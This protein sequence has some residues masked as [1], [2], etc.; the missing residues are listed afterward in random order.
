MRDHVQHAHRRL[1]ADRQPDHHDHGAP[2]GAE[3][4]PEGRQVEPRL[5]REPE[6][7]ALL[8][9]QPE[10]PHE[11]EDEHRGVEHVH[12]GVVP[13]EGPLGRL[14][15]QV[16]DQVALSECDQVESAAKHR[17]RSPVPDHSL[18]RHQHSF[19]LARCAGG[20]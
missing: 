3:R 13:G 11:Q 12:K 20:S 17:G 10:C 8:Q 5:A 15:E 6:I 19:L 7:A 1:A 2:D 4:E 18:P 14:R 9:L 16:V